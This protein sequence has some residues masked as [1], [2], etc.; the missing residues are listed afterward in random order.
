LETLRR[1]VSQLER[2]SSPVASGRFSN[3]SGEID[4]VLKGGLHRGGVHEIFAADAGG[5][6]SASG[7]AVV[8]AVRA[9]EKR[10]V[11]WVRQ[12]FVGIEAGEIYAPGLLELG[13]SPERLILVRVRDGPAALRAGE[14]AIR[15][16]PLGAVLIEPW[17]SPKVLDLSASRRL[18]LPAPTFRCSW[19]V[20]ERS[21]SRAR[22]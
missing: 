22:R 21:R 5:E 19:C 10:P 2:S 16:P 15:C 7:F 12:D 13:L 3:G 6:S 9:A 18:A 20:S 4:A 14:E 1:R 11:L 17:G 8:L